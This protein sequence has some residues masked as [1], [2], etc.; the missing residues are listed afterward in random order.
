MPGAGENDD[1]QSEVKSFVEFQFSHVI[2]C[3]TKTTRCRLISNYC[4]KRG[5]DVG[6]W[7]IRATSAGKVFSITI[8]S[9]AV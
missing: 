9:F 2:K 1:E 8:R 6:G 3:R 4:L 7:R 5:G